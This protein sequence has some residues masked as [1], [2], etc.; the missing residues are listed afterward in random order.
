MKFV[1]N[2]LF[3]KL[4]A[5][6]L[7]TTFADATKRRW[8]NWPFLISNFAR[9]PK[10][11]VWSLKYLL[12]PRIIFLAMKLIFIGSLAIMASLLVKFLLNNETSIAL[13]ALKWS[14]KQC[15]IVQTKKYGNKSTQKRLCQ[16][17]H[18]VTKCCLSSSNNLSSRTE[19][20]FSSRWVPFLSFW[21]LKI[22][23]WWR[24]IYQSFRHL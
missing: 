17:N 23:I 22:Y 18:I 8:W 7:I 11:H 24:M 4:Q 9:N 19:V 1:K 14:N 15:K 16:V 6:S 13:N 20:P 21:L 3:C 5:S 2:T 12:H 10:S